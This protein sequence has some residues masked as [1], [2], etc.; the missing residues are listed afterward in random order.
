M[1]LRQESVRGKLAIKL[2]FLYILPNPDSTAVFF[3]GELFSWDEWVSLFW[4][5][6]LLFL[7]SLSLQT[8]PQVSFSLE[9]F[10]VNMNWLSHLQNVRYMYFMTYFSFLRL[11]HSSFIL[12]RAKRRHRTILKH[13]F[14]IHKILEKWWHLISW[15]I[16]LMTMAIPR[17][18]QSHPWQFSCWPEDSGVCTAATIKS[19]KFFLFLILSCHT[20][21]S[22]SWYMRWLYLMWSSRDASSVPHWHRRHRMIAGSGDMVST[23]WS[24]PSLRGSLKY[25]EAYKHV[26]WE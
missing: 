4:K 3:S 17:M 26:H 18:S 12:W 8:Y 1:H 5:G 14:I 11:C 6:T 2:K 7:N 13:I 21:R 10:P 15:K 23:Q 19:N 22:C 16:L 25:L 20:L 9:I 24:G